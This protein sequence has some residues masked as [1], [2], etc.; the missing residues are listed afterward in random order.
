[1]LFWWFF[2]FERKKEQLKKGDWRLVFS[3]FVI[4][5]KKIIKIIKKPL[6]SL[7]KDD[8]ILNCIII[9]YY[10]LVDGS[11]GDVEICFRYYYIRV[12]VCG[13]AV[14]AEFADRPKMRILF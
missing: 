4:L 8:I 11:V 10:A 5:Y 12:Y 13:G 2:L 1:M 6:T 3:F 14:G 9:A 7:D